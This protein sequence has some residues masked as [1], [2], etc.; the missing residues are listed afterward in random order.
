MEY[1]ENNVENDLSNISAIL[2][3]SMNK[4]CFYSPILK[5]IFD[6]KIFRKN[7]TNS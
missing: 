4:S 3:T 5:D 1:D 2:N 7:N 6:Y